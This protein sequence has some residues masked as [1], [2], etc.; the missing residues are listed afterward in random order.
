MHVPPCSCQLLKVASSGCVGADH[1]LNLFVIV[2]SAV[3]NVDTLVVHLASAVVAMDAARDGRAQVASNSPK[4]NGHE[5]DKD[6]EGRA[7][8]L[9]AQEVVSGDVGDLDGLHW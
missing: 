5:D 4:K 1:F 7:V 2:S 6:A 9:G 8:V 3:D